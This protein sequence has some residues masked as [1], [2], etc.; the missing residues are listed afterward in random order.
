MTLGRT[1][2]GADPLPTDKPREFRCSNCRARCTRSPDGQTEYGHATGCPDRP[3]EFPR[4]GKYVKNADH[5]PAGDDPVVTDGGRDTFECEDCG[6]QV[7]TEDRWR[8]MYPDQPDVGPVQYEQLC[9]EC[10][11]KKASQRL[12]RGADDQQ[13]GDVE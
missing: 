12:F 11:T 2:N 7:L 9:P 6:D 10:S 3:S 8:Y 4:G 13:R 5:A 1:T